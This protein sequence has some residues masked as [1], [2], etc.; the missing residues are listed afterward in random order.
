MISMPNYSP[1]AGGCIISY[2]KHA[3][4]KAILQYKTTQ[5]RVAD[6]TSSWATGLLGEDPVVLAGSP[7]SL[8]NMAGASD[9]EK[10]KKGGVN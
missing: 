10:A 2:S 7:N 1:E 8:D 4:H 3:L 9:K 5:P 6:V